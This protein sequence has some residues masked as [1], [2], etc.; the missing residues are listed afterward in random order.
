MLEHP[1]DL[2][3]LHA[4]VDKKSGGAPASN[5]DWSRDETV[6]LMALY[7][8]HPKAEKR[9]PEVVALSALLRGAALARGAA[10]SPTYRNPAGIAMKLRNFAKYDPSPTLPLGAGLRGGGK[11]DRQVWGSSA[12][13]MRLS[14]QKSSGSAGRSRRGLIGW[15]RRRGVQGLLSERKS[16]FV[17]MLQGAYTSFSSMGLSISW[18]R[19]GRIRPPP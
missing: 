14:P 15:K 5:A 11:V 19:T 18:R 17:T 7:R 13:T 9:H 1:Q 3:G 8:R 10:L 6:L 16:M 2:R 12:A 4:M